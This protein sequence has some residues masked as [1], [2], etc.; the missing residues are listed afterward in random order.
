M[1]PAVT[2]HSEHYMAL[3]STAWHVRPS[4]CKNAWHTRQLPGGSKGRGFEKVRMTSGGSTAWQASAHSRCCQSPTP[5]PKK[6]GMNAVQAYHAAPRDAYSTMSV[7]C[8]R[9]HVCRGRRRPACTP[10]CEA[11]DGAQKSAHTPRLSTGRPH[12]RGASHPCPA[13][14]APGGVGLHIQHRLEQLIGHERHRDAGQHL[15]GRG[16][17]VE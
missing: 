5:R 13:R 16:T 7:G 14:S 9:F 3:G 4:T 17:H 12:P 10:R 2:V 15:Q 11:W 1:Q 6:Q 8:F